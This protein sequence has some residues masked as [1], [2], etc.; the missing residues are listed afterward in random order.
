VVKHLQGP[1]FIEKEGGGKG[2]GDGG[3]VEERR[4]MRGG[5]GREGKELEVP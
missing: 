4:R 3:S 5:K 2:R 1:G